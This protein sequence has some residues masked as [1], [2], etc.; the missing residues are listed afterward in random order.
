[1][2]NSGGGKV[3]VSVSSGYIYFAMGVMLLTALTFARL[4]CPIDGG[5]GV[6][7]GAEGLKVVDID[8]KLIDYKI[9][10]TGCQEIYSDFTYTVNISLVNEASVPRLGALLVK[11][12]HPS[13]VKSSVNI[14][15]AIRQRAEE[16]EAPEQAVVVTEEVSKGGMIATFTKRPVATK[17]V[18]VEISARTAETV[19]ET[20][21]FRGFGYEEIVG[22][23][24]EGAKHA[25]SI[26]PPVET[27]ICPYSR[28]TGKLP[29]IEWLKLKARF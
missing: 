15:T 27:I 2:L 13:A 24:T 5:T 10:D 21:N 6:I 29:L 22:F 12:Y 25:V 23:G 1:M 28:G 19:E 8:D 17:L 9:F 18:F 11:F 14:E 16:Q 20:M 7:T 3:K 26:A 4:T